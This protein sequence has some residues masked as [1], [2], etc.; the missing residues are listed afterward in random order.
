MGQ[1][2]SIMPIYSS[3]YQ[4]AYDQ[5]HHD[6]ARLD[7]PVTLLVDRAGLVGKDGETHQGIFDTSSIN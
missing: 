5:V 6:I 1:F 4:R 7:L 2:L 3:F